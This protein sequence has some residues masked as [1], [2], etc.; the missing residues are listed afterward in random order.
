MVERLM[1]VVIN[2]VDRRRFPWLAEEREPNEA[3]RNAAT[4]AS[5]CLWAYQRLQADRRNAGKE[6]LEG[7]TE[8]CL[9]DIGFEKQEKRKINLLSDAPEAGAFFLETACAGRQADFVVGLWD[10]RTMM[11]ECKDSNSFVNSIKRLNNDTAAKADFWLDNFG[12]R[13]IVPV[14]IISG[15]FELKALTRA[16]ETG[17]SLFWGHDMESFK[18]WIEKTRREVQ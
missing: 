13:G 7:R 16:Q 10:G 8:Q 17:L 6:K 11:I 9:K 12:H 3:E 4:L 5:A 2:T 14:A 1:Q 18:N 15:V